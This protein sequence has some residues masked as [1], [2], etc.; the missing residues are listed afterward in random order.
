MF[1]LEVKLPLQNT[2]SDSGTLKFSKK[3]SLAPQIWWS[4][5]YMDT[6]WVSVGRDPLV[7]TEAHVNSAWWKEQQ[8]GR[9]RGQ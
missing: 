4:V 9:T 2:F 3:S 5:I 8:A 7:V 6:M 1:S